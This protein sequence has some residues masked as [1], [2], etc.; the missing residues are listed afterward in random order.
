VVTGVI[1]VAGAHEATWRDIM[2]PVALKTKAVAAEGRRLH[3][4]GAYVPAEQVLLLFR[5]YL[6]ALREVIR[7]PELLRRVHSRTL[8]Y[9]P[10][11]LRRSE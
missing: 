7:D 8:T 10:P 2:E 5:A 6:A 9:L 3:D 1:A 11:E 4:L